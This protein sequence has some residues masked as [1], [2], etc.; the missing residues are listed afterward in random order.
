MKNLTDD[1]ELVEH[2]KIDDNKVNDIMQNVIAP[3]HKER[4]INILSNTKFSLLVDEYTDR[5]VDSYMC[6]NVRYI[7][8]QKQKIVD[9]LW[10]L[11]QV[12]NND[13]K[14]K[15]T[16]ENLYEKIVST[17]TV[18]RVDPKNIIAF[19]SDGANVMKGYKNS[20]LTRFENMNPNV[21]HIQCKYH[22]EHLCARDGVKVFPKEYVNMCSAIYNYISSGAS[23]MNKWKVVKKRMGVRP[24]IIL[25]PY[26]TRW[27]EYYNDILRILRR[28]R[29]EIFFPMGSKRESRSFSFTKTEQSAE[30]ILQM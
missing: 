29:S 14:K 3:A 8:N 9:T 22:I 5:S 24:L 17:F 26:A 10:E 28:Y 16:A 12:Y 6:L 4:L 20:V 13:E 7:D 2:I 1:S 18:V 25:K 30:A 27:L 15:A 11:V 21:I 23:R 19:C